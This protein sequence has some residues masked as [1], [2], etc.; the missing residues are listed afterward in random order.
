MPRARV[1]A[2][3]SG[4]A[5]AQHPD[6]FSRPVLAAFVVEMRAAG[7]PASD[8]H[9]M[10]QALM[11][12][13]SR[14]RVGGTAIIAG[15]SVILPG[16]FRCLSLLLAADER[17]VALARDTAGLSSASIHAAVPLRDSGDDNDWWMPADLP[18]VQ[19]EKEG[20]LP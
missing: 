18:R 9:G 4:V 13:V 20:E 1:R 5:S 8:L 2:D 11:Y 17:S 15:S 12:A 7:S 14:L 6:E 10:R 3:A 16:D 19:P